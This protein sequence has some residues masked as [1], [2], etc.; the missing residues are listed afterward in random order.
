MKRRLSAVL[1]VVLLPLWSSPSAAAASF[2]R[3]DANADG[4]VDLAD[5]VTVLFRVFLGGAEPP[6][7]DAADADDS[8]SLDITDPITVL[9]Y[10]FIEGRSPKSPFPECGL[11]PTADALGCASFPPCAGVNLP[12]RAAFSASARTG[13][14]PLKVDV[15]AGASNDPDG[16]LVSYLW[17]FGDG[18][19]AQGAKASHTFD[20]TGSFTVTLTVKD[21][22]G[23]TSSSTLGVVVRDP[24][25]PPD[26]SDV[27]P[28]LDGTSVP[29]FAELTSFL[30]GATD[31]I[32]TGVDPDA[33]VA[34]RAAVLRGRVMDRAGAP[35][36]SVAVTVLGH[37]ELG[38]TLTRP[39]GMFDLVV[40]GGGTVIVDYQRSGFLPAQRQVDVPWN[41]Y[42]WLP[43]V[44][45]IPLD[46]QVTAI[47]PA[48]AAMQTARGSAMTDADGT[49]QA[50][51]LFPQG[52]TAQMVLPDGTKQPLASLHVRATEYT[53]GAHGPE[54]M[55]AELPPTSGYTYC[56]ELTVDE[57]QA[58][59]ATTVLFSTPLPFY[60]ENFLGFP[61]G[62][63][64]PVGSYD[65]ARGLWI[66]ED[67]GKVVK[68]LSVTGG[69]ADL[70]LDGDGTADGPAA[71][72]A[73]AI[74]DAERQRVAALYAPGQSLWRV[75]MPHFS[76]INWPTG[77]PD[78]AVP[79]D[80][81][82]NGD[83][84]MDAC[85]RQAGNSVI[86]VQNQI[87][88]EAVSVIGTPFGLHYQSERVP[89]RKLAYSIDIPLSGDKDLPK[90][91]KQIELEVSVAGQFFRDSFPPLKSQST[92]FTWNGK[93]AYGQILQGK[94]PIHVRIGYTYPASYGG[95][96]KFGN[97]GPAI[98]VS[99]REVTLWRTWDGKV[100]SWDARG[101]GLG[102]WTLSVHHAYDAVEQV[103]FR[104]DGGR[105][106]AKAVG[107][108]I[109]T[110]AGGG[111]PPA[112]QL[113]D[114][115]P[116]TQALVKP[117]G[118]AS[119]ADGSLYIVDSLAA[120][121]RRV[122]PDG[123]I[124]TVAGPGDCGAAPCGDG[125]PATKAGIGFPLA[126]TVGPDGS[127]YFGGVQV[128]RRVTP[129]GIIHTIA[130][131][132]TL[133]DAGDGGPALQA[134]LG[135]VLGLAV[136][137]DGS[138]FFT[139]STGRRV[140]RVTP[141]GLISS[142]AGTGQFGSSGDGGPA[143]VAQF[144][145]PRGVAIGRDGTLYIAD[146]GAERIRSVTPDGIIHTIA[147]TGVLGYSGDGGPAVDAT[148]HF[149]SDVAI[150]PDDTLYIVDSGNNVV[151]WMRP[152]GTIHTLAGNG[153]SGS[154]GDGGS[155]RQAAF[156]ALDHGLAVGADGSI[157]V[158]QTFATA[159]VPDGL[160]VRRISPPPETFA[161][162][163]SGE[164]MVPAQDGGE[165]Y[166]FDLNGRHLRTLE[167]LTGSL[168]Y[169][170]SYD[171]AGRLAEVVDGD[172][173]TTA[174]ERD[175]SGNPT[176][177]VGPFGQATALDVNAD[178]FL[179]RVTDP[180]GES[181]RLSYT[182][183]GLLTSFT[184]PRGHASSYG[185]DDDGRLT[186]A[187]DPT[188][189]KK[190]LVRTGKD[191]D[192]TITVTTA[193]GQTTAHRVETQKNGDQRLTTSDCAGLS[194]QSTVGRDGRLSATYADGSRVD[195]VLGPD[196]RWGMRA[197]IAASLTSVTAGGHSMT[198]TSQSAVTLAAPGDLL[199][200]SSR[201]ESVTTNGRTWTS[202][203][204]G[205]SRTLVLTSPA[206]RSQS[207]TFDARGRPGT[208]KSP[209]LEPIGYQ[210]DGRG[211]LSTI[212]QGGGADLRV[213]ALSYG[214]DGF[215]AGSTDPLG[216]TTTL[217]RDDAG[218]VTEQ[219]LPGGRTFRLA[220]DADGNAVGITP[221]GGIGHAVAYSPRNE[222]A[223][224]TPPAAGAESAV[225]RYSY[226]ADRRPTR[227]DQPGGGAVQ[228]HYEDATCRLD[229]LDL[230]VRQRTYGYDAAGRLTSLVSSGGVSLAHAFDDGL[231]TAATWSGAVSGSVSWTY[232]GDFRMSTLSVDGGNPVAIAY[233]ADGLPVQVGG[234]TLTRSAVSGRLVGSSLGALSDSV[235]FNG[236][237]DLTSYT[238]KRGGTALYS[239]AYDCDA[240]GR[241]QRKVETVGGV[242]RMIDYVF[243]S[244]G[245]LT[246]VRRDDVLTASYVYDSNGNRHSRTDSDGKLFGTY[247]AQDRLV[248][249]GSTT[250][251]HDAKGER[252]SRTAGGQTTTYRY[253]GMGNLVGATLPDGT[254]I[255]YL[256]D[257]RDRRV[258]KRVN[259]ALV[260]AFL[261]LD[262]L[263]P[264]AELDGAGFVVNRFVYATGGNVPDYLLKGGVAYRIVTD[265]VGTPRL[266]ID[267]ATGQVVQQM[268]HDEFGRVVLDT[269]PGFQ[270]FGFAGGLYDRQ[271]GLVHFGAREYDPET[272]RWT[273]KDPIGFS[274]GDGNLYAYAG[275]E[276]I[277]GADPSGLMLSTL[278]YHGAVVAATGAV[279]GVSQFAQ[280]NAPNLYAA[281]A[282]AGRG[283]QTAGRGLANLGNRISNFFCSS[284]SS[285]GNQGIAVAPSPALPN[286]MNV[287]G[288]TLQGMAV[289][290]SPTLQQAPQITLFFPKL[291]EAGSAFRYSYAQYEKL[292]GEFI[293][294]RDELAGVYPGGPPVTIDELEQAHQAA[295][296]IFGWD[297]S[298]SIWF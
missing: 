53:V 110:F 280:R 190:T 239:V 14:A 127:F 11:D 37:P 286:A 270:P 290:P 145:D 212:E 124:D 146:A 288:N 71:L 176:A 26:P 162:G 152:G 148:F 86:E 116:A 144:S 77:P 209:E 207:V 17:D 132:G 18:G 16:Q 79:P 43:D 54:A 117:S 100:G 269:N 295:V 218:R 282:T 284:G 131:N 24:G 254:V 28:A 230:G 32:Q 240:L 178:G 92:R 156:F 256:L 109:G 52:T 139:G 140:R 95:P 186:S 165:V 55:P 291:G 168:L 112:G 175:G 4:A 48:A 6:C 130:G 36:R 72:A 113:G 47:D 223:A 235:T 192:F 61:V 34:R 82:P 215:L 63:T 243:D 119:G 231:L 2:V 30:H 208:T 128:I 62:T 103:L 123:L 151:R 245:R 272:G 19:T 159:Q 1:A 294:L 200:I 29:S 78:D 177:I 266:V 257:A 122:T 58:A 250:Y 191:E 60:L 246:D 67:S 66:P 161:A 133:G 40:N 194:S 249:F 85:C 292:V 197:P 136:G 261:Y 171:S 241:I 12:P 111:Q 84:P 232:D 80:E 251:G 142:Y 274:G 263:R 73:L 141:D 137:P 99:R 238:V 202:T 23:A 75:R 90:S 154:T 203:Y 206:G 50:T 182:P 157:F 89:G 259:G 121:I 219:T 150:A 39:D 267:T 185:Y 101:N 204:D 158:S 120:R 68:V 298:P 229:L 224:Y 187:T 179:D 107:S 276:P 169:G 94:Q 173:N 21:D 3:G 172:G 183:D 147:G 115:G 198:T 217:V 188:G 273:A 258:G 201:T 236:F 129:D 135:H 228:F 193:L 181:V 233:D 5:A 296:K 163:K 88:G 49:R 213:A 244:A 98:G 260:Q 35:L 143:A 268:D 57:A 155:A 9:S 64:V 189:A 227:I 44:A 211:R 170:F 289:A 65:R 275:N 42:R 69:A 225:I 214:A 253:D 184:G 8:G 13:V 118:L 46:A 164:L 31:P 149:P 221:P 220:Y 22:R 166:V 59:G 7:L 134:Q 167:G 195:L 38:S 199:H 105:Q 153:F 293:E 252:T 76:D 114:G 277:N 41:D 285:G 226:D 96:S 108:T 74:T 87:L 247:D 10:L 281:A 278:C 126:V 265:Q 196:P 283:L 33:I 205:A 56:V 248:Q 271:T 27:A 102:G 25:V 210:Y 264:V 106:S 297:P 234:M 91:L 83:Q 70:D 51:L 222:A 97:S 279:Y 160:R 15:D 45:L 20:K 262:G 104:G 174:V 255:E 81:D 125:G 242:T 138:L 287:A 180:A 216:R 93:N 237:G